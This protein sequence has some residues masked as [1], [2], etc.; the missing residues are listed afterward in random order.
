MLTKGLKKINWTS[1]NPIVAILSV[2]LFKKIYGKK[3]Y[4]KNIAKNF[5]AEIFYGKIFM[6]TFIMENFGIAICFFACFI[7]AMSSE[8]AKSPY[9]A[10]PGPTCFP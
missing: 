6:V 8:R 7:W 10:L 9:Q 2:S 1:P 3:F 5:T 4:E